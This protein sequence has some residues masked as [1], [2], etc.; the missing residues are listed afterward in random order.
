MFKNKTKQPS[1]RPNFSHIFL[2][3]QPKTKATYV[4]HR[5]PRLPRRSFEFE[6]RYG[7][8]RCTNT[9][10]MRILFEINALLSLLISFSLVSK[11]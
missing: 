3:T 10:Q 1:C 11:N 2:Y 8:T 9:P 5:I 7:K 6:D 4:V